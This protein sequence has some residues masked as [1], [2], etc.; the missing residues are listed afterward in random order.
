MTDD[1][2]KK[3][4]ECRAC[5]QPL[6][7]INIRIAD[8]CP[9]NSGRG[10]NHG[11]VPKETCTC[12]ECDP[13]QTG[14]TRYQTE[15]YQADHVAESLNLPRDRA[16][17]NAWCRTYYTLDPDVNRIIDQHA[18][19]LARSY[20]LID[21]ASAEANEFCKQQ[22][23]TL[24]MSNLLL[25][26]FSQFLVHGEVFPYL[27][28]DDDSG[29]WSKVI[30]QNPDYVVVK[31]KSVEDDRTLFLR[32][33]EE[34]KRLCYSNRPED[35]K[36]RK[37]L[38]LESV[39]CVRQGRNVPMSS[40]NATHLSRKVSPYEIR[41]TSVLVPLLKT[42]EMPPSPERT[43]TIRRT[44]GDIPAL[45]AIERD[46]LL[47]RYRYIAEAFAE[48]LNTKIL[49]PACTLNGYRTDLPKVRFDIGWIRELLADGSNELP[50]AADIDAT[51]QAPVESSGMGTAIGIGLA[52]LAGSLISTYFTSTQGS[53]RVDASEDTVSDAIE[54]IAQEATS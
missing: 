2:S 45:S 50:I 23:E 12:V 3:H 33:D 7:P 10:I 39:E 22:L 11:L 53:V 30:I 26:L 52:G 8:C 40:F 49:E 9:C 4:V 5:G 1:T 32:P 31:R 37:E 38:S 24:G 6:L 17:I 25:E 44:L 19:L 20:R 54:S 48:W 29:E 21:G 42:L 27:V 15:V 41:G 47:I 46:V 51:E 16:T 43:A 18:Y 35:I 36:T 13:E 14:S 34:L 28:R